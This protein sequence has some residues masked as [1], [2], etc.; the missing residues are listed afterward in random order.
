MQ[1]E[2]NVCTCGTYSTTS[3]GNNAEDFKLY[4]PT[5]NGND[6]LRHTLRDVGSDDVNRPY[7][8]GT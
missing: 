4:R 1:K 8:V 2:G 7:I 5:R 3:L 6:N